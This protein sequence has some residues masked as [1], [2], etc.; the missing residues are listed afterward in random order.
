MA[1]GLRISWI[2]PACE[3]W[4]CA[5]AI[6]RRVGSARTATDPIEGKEAR[7]EDEIGSERATEQMSKR[8]KEAMDED[9]VEVQVRPPMWGRVSLWARVT[10]VGLNV[11]QRS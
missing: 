9:E 7:T 11:S 8:T 10:C 3:L 4:A 2:A 6:G 5:H 1:P